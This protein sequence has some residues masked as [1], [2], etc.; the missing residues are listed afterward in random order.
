MLLPGLGR[1]L[2]SRYVGGGFGRR[3]LRGRGLRGCRGGLV[4]FGRWGGG[5]V[6]GCVWRVGPV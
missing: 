1:D 6:F 4:R 2:W 3:L 5:L